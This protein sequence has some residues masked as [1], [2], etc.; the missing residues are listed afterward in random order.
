MLQ[1]LNLVRRGCVRSTI[2]S[3]SASTAATIVKPPLEKHEIGERKLETF[4]KSGSIF[5]SH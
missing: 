3:H 4:Q 2:Y 5:I 1:I